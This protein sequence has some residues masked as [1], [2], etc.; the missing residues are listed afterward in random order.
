MAGEC[1][2][3]Q[4]QTP[5]VYDGVAALFIQREKEG[6]GEIRHAQ[7]RDLLTI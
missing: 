6:F 5:R 2:H 4:G 7:T 1:L 3:D